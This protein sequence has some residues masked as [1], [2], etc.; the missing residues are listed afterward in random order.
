MNMWTDSM[1][2]LQW[3][4]GSARRWK[5]FVANRVTEIQTKS[6]PETWNHCKGT[7]NPADLP[8]RGLKAEELVNSRFW[9]EGPLWLKEDE[10]SW[11]KNTNECSHLPSEETRS[12]STE[13]VVL[14]TPV[15]LKGR[16]L[17]NL[18]ELKNYSSLRKVLRVTAW[19]QRFVNN[20]RNPKKRKEGPL[21]SEETTNANKFW[22]KQAQEE[23]YGSDIAELKQGRA[24][25]KDSKIA[26][27]NPVLDDDGLLY[28]G[29]RLQKA[30]FSYQEKHPWIIPSKHRILELITIFHH[31][32]LKHGG[33]RDTLTDIRENY[34][35]PK[36]RQ[37]VK[38]IIQRCLICKAFQTKQAK[39][40]MAPLP[41]DRIRER[42]PFDVCGIDFAGPLFT[43][44]NRQTSKTYIVLF[45]CAVTR[46]IHLEAASSLSTEMFLLA[47]RRFIARR[48]VPS[49]VYSD[50]A[51]T[52]KRA[53]KD[54]QEIWKVLK[55]PETQELFGA[56]GITWKFIVERAA[57]WGG[58][59]ER[60]VRSVKTALKK[61]LGRAF[62]SYEELETILIEVEAIL[63]SRP[64]TFVYNDC[65]EP[66]LLYQD[67]S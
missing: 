11:P 20:S 48:G 60:M 31:E 40:Y 25:S 61:G 41:I 53:D 66:A 54:L 36:G 21:T 22:I 45:T 14:A 10:E 27:L 38:S 13:Q 5:P 18:L 33:L 9:W 1:I 17:P 12:L 19:I 64:L 52:F 43:K 16:D 49:I 50:N 59:W 8:T 28:V 3:I 63:N 57:W 65:N 32:K 2:A 51:K 62:L 58:F 15:E 55:G 24:I 39:M 42:P 37:I 26:N 47:L 56:H 46:A 35:I 7:D 34:W 30:E 6:D 44:G 67:I 4:K 23:V 29:G